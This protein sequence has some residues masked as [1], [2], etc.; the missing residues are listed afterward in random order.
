MTDDTTRDAFVVRTTE[1]A[2]ALAY[3]EA[4]VRRMCELGELHCVRAGNRWRIH[5]DWLERL[6]KDTADLQDQNIKDETSRRIGRAPVRAAATRKRYNALL[7]ARAKAAI[8]CR[9]CGEQEDLSN[10]VCRICS[11]A[12]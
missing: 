4:T 12:V 7:H 11:V 8:V 3:N 6:L 9:K 10:G 2:A 1:V 5:S